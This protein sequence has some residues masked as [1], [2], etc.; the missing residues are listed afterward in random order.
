MVPPVALEGGVTVLWFGHEMSSNGSDVTFLA[1]STVLRDGAS[2]LRLDRE[3]S[4]PIS[5]GIY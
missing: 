2:G 4:D 5:G 3:G 1:P